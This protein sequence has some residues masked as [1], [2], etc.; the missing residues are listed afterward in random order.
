VGS[1][2]L[3]FETQQRASTGYVLARD[4]WGRGY[5]SEALAAVVEL[6]RELQI[7]RLY[8]LCHVDHIASARV[9]GRC[10]FLE[11]GVLRRYQVFPDPASSPSDVRRISAGFNALVC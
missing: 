6:A 8:A 10:G 5:A 9:L 11:E 4:A 3:D 7:A 1:T 2:G